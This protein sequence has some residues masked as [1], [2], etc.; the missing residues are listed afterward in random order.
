LLKLLGG[1]AVVAAVFYVFEFRAAAEWAEARAGSGASAAR[2]EALTVERLA[3]TSCPGTRRACG[4]L[5]GKQTLYRGLG[6]VGTW[7]CSC[8]RAAASS[9][10]AGACRER[11]AA[12]ARTRGGRTL[13][14]GRERAGIAAFSNP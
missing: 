7:R 6:T 3:L 5:P 10:S 12:K 8:S 14:G 9:L 2:I 1:C 11:R 13:I 4:V